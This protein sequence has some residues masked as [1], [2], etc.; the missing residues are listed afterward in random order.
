MDRYYS[1]FTR[2]RSNLIK[3]LAAFALVKLVLGEN[4]VS[5]MP[6]MMQWV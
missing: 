2:L 4:A 5:L 1:A 3:M 6:C